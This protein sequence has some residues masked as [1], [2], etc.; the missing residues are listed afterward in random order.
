MKDELKGIF[1]QIQAEEELKDSTKAF[2]RKKTREYTQVN[3][4]KRKYY[5]PAAICVC[6]LFLLAGGHWLYFVP[7]A[8]ISID[9]NPSI[10]LGINRFDQVISVNHFNEDG[11]EL[12]NALD[13]KFKNYTEAI[14]QIL[15]DDRI[16]TLLSD[17]E[18]MTITVAGSDGTQ[19]AEILSE[20]EACTA[21]HRDTYCY[22]VSSEEIA[23]AH[24]T[25]L[26]YG[27]YRAFLELQLLDP[28]ITPETVQNMTMREIRELTES[29]S[30]GGEKET[31]PYNERGTG[32]H[33]HGNGYRG[34]RG[35]KEHCAGE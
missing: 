14:E 1:G 16:V 29:L 2:L 13:V 35:K 32:N 23:G 17:N 4:G 9:I 31:A 30:T 7:T 15:N 8:E 22:F 34:G 21:H 12:S 20:V 27:K 25:G 28:Y 10:E 19:S 26:S 11:A 33:G 5:V 18:I 24:E 6:L 3:A